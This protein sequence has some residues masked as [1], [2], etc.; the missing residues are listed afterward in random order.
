MVKDTNSLLTHKEL[1]MLVTLSAVDSLRLDDVRCLAVNVYEVVRTLAGLN[2]LRGY[3]QLR[4][5]LLLVERVVLELKE[6]LGECHVRQTFDVV[7]ACEHRP[8]S[9]T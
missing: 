5:V 7:V 1:K 2:H 4:Q 8:S 6:E 9:I 3:P